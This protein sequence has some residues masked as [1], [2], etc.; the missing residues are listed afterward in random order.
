MYCPDCGARNDDDAIYCTNCGA[1]L[2]VAPAKALRATQD[3]LSYL[4][5]FGVSGLAVAAMFAGLFAV[6]LAP[7]PIALLLG[8]LAVRDIRRNPDKLGMGRAIFG[9]VMGAVG[10]VVLLVAVV[11]A[12]AF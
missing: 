1:E 5:P 8:I 6:L 2:Q 4:L 7:A 10:T 3:D 12:L 9:L 11:A